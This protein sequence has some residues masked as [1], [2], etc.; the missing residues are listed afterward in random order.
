MSADRRLQTAATGN[1]LQSKP[2]VEFTAIVRSAAG[3]ACHRTAYPA[4]AG[5]FLVAIWALIN[6]TRHVLSCRKWK[7]MTA[8]LIGDCQIVASLSPF[9][10]VRQ[11]ASPA[12]AKLS[13]NMSKFVSQSPIDFVRML[14]QLR[15]ERNEF[16]AIISAT[17]GCFET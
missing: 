15:V 6:K 1:E 7:I 11:D 4:D 16:L 10:S 2:R 9:G 13:E 17:S 8:L 5:K 3:Q 12:S 14:K